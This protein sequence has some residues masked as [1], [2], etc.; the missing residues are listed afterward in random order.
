MARSSPQDH[1]RT[2]PSDRLVYR[3][4]R[5]ELYVLDGSGA[6]CCW[7]DLSIPELRNP[8]WGCA[9]IAQQIT[10]AFGL[11]INKDVVRRNLAARW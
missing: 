11:P 1:K 8:S 6:R 9:R 5:H 3:G 10:L 7:K 2:A 4:E